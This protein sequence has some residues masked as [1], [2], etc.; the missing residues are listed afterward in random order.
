MTQSNDRLDRIERNLEL[1][2][3]QINQRQ[4]LVERQADNLAANQLE[5]RDRRLELREDLEILEQRQMQTQTQ[6]DAL[7]AQIQALTAQMTSNYAAEAQ[8]RA[9]FQRQMLGLQQES[10]NILREL[11]DLRRQER[12]N[13]E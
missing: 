12:S 10:R 7:T 4:I 5:E 1:I 6:I 13:G 8:T 9:E 3:E 2:Q 11:A